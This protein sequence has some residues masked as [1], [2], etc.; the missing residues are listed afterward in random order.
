MCK[1]VDQILCNL[2]RWLDVDRFEKRIRCSPLSSELERRVFSHKM[3][4]MLRII[5]ADEMQNKN[6]N[7]Y[8]LGL[9]IFSIQG[10]GS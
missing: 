8:L 7:D 9:S 10:Q 2:K 6:N 1:A 3:A 5:K 4:A